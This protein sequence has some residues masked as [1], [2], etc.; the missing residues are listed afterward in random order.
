[1]RILVVLFLALVLVQ[2][3]AIAQNMHNETRPD[4]ITFIDLQVGS[5]GA[6]MGI[7]AKVRNKLATGI[8]VKGLFNETFY[9][10]DSNYIAGFKAKFYRSNLPTSL[11]AGP[12]IGAHGF[13]SG[14]RPLAGVNLGFDHY[15][16]FVSL[17]RR[18]EFRF[19][20]EIQMGLD[21]NNKGFI[22]IGVGMGFGW[23]NNPVRKNP[24]EF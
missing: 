20:V 12:V 9:N 21:T 7:S 1:M 4:F 18:T 14:F 17:E 5:T 15:T 13:G 16:G 6:E 10:I 22:G 19:G 23:S 2:P 3:G 11:Y 24:L 8:F